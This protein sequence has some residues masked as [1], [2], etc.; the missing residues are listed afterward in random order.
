MGTTAGSTRSPGASMVGTN[1]RSRPHASALTT[2]LEPEEE[3]IAL[4]PWP[5]ITHTR[6]HRARGTRETALLR[7]T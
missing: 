2:A 6:T 4:R 7:T 1:H 3:A 5:Q